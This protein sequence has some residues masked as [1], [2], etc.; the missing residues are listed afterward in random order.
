MKHPWTTLASCCSV[1]AR[2]LLPMYY[3]HK[4]ALPL[5]RP[6]FQCCGTEIRRI[7]WLLRAGE[8]FSLLWLT[9][10]WR[11]RLFCYTSSTAVNS[12]LHFY[13][14]CYWATDCRQEA[15]ARINALDV[16]ITRITTILQP[17]IHLPSAFSLLL[18]LLILLLTIAVWQPEYLFF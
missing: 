6:S 17:H 9:G 7:S 2:Y 3:W 16:Y 8:R 12:F 4:K 10:E 15:N 11:K 13:S 18:L 5:L 1:S 14:S